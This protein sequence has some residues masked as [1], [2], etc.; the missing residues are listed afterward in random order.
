MFRSGGFWQTK[1]QKRDVGVHKLSEQDKSIREGTNLDL[2]IWT[3][4]SRSFKSLKVIV[5]KIAHDNMPVV[6]EL[7]LILMLNSQVPGLTWD[8]YH[9]CLSKFFG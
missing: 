1:I 2:K 3:R 7:N 6:H 4:T 8:T 5:F 9:M